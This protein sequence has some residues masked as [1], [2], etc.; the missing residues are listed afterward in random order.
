MIGCNTQFGTFKDITINSSNSAGDRTLPSYY[1]EL[2]IP[3]VTEVAG[4]SKTDKQKSNH[5][6]GPP[7]EEFNTTVSNVLE[8]LVSETT[9]GLKFIHLDKMRISYKN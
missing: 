4:A 5:P 3:V 2:V 6:P 8:I 7:V 1:N 9:I